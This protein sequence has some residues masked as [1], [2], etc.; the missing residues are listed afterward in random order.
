MINLYRKLKKIIVL[1]SPDTL[2]K[3][4]NNI[5]EDPKEPNFE[6]ENFG[7]DNSDKIFYV[8]KRTPGTGFFLI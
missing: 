5:T 8:I 4:H 2:F 3:E 6:V 1:Q 7:D